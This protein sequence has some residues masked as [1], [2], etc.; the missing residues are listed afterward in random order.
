M[1]NKRQRLARKNF[2][3]VTGGDTQPKQST[4]EAEAKAVA[5][6]E[7]GSSKPV[8]KEKK[9]SKQIGTK[10]KAPEEN[11]ITHAAQPSAVAGGEGSEVRVSLFAEIAILCR[12]V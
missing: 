3:V 10:R 11:E 1:G 5:S 12:D 6:S 7:N 2:K 4:A 9:K 8:K